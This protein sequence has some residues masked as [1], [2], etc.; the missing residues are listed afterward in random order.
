MLKI[1]N[2]LIA[3][4]GIFATV[5]LFLVVILSSYLDTNNSL[6]F[7]EISFFISPY[8]TVHTVAVPLYQLYNLAV[9]LFSFCISIR[10][11]YEYAKVGALCL[12][13]SGIIGLSLVRFPMD[14]PYSQLTI[15]G[16]THITLVSILSLY[17]IAAM[18]LFGHA[19]HHM[20]NI[21]WLARASYTIS[22]LLFVTGLVTCIIASYNSRLVGILE[23]LPILTFLFWILLVV[24]GMIHSDRRIKYVSAEEPVQ[25]H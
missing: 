7:N 13:F 16:I 11:K 23:K 1:E 10:M 24:I 20:I 3:F 17:I 4:Y 2:I 6:I 22:K 25:T 14:P 15:Q 8:S 19:F 5:I 18:Y 9:L 21:I 12:S